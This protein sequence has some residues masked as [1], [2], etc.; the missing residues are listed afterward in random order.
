ML[1]LIN[2]PVKRNKIKY[3]RIKVGTARCIYWS[4]GTA[5]H[6]P[7]KNVIN[8]FPNVRSQAQELPVDAMQ[9]G[10]QEISLSWVFAVKQVQQLG[11]S[12]QER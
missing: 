7:I 2:K 6:S 3:R 1:R 5:S 10:L 8:L 11:S 12:G 9:S 4:V